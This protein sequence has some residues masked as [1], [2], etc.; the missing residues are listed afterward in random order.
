MIQ[1][2]PGDN[3]GVSALITSPKR[4]YITVSDRW[5]RV[6]DGFTSPWAQRARF[7]VYDNSPWAFPWVSVA[8]PSV[9]VC[10][11]NI[12]GRLDAEDGSI[13][14]AQITVPQV[15]NV[16]EFVPGPFTLTLS[17]QWQGNMV[18]LGGRTYTYYS[19]WP[20]S[21]YFNLTGTLGVQATYSSLVGSG[22]PPTFTWQ[23]A[24]WVARRNQIKT[25]QIPEN[26]MRFGI[27]LAPYGQQT[28]GGWGQ[29]GPLQGYVFPSRVPVI[30][31]AGDNFY[32]DLETSYTYNNGVWLNPP[33]E[34][35]E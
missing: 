28:G 22:A 12:H 17:G 15:I 7:Y 16:V 26:W 25:Y 32:W 10:D 30:P 4:G 20:C 3:V 24:D 1:R 18:T 21:Y 6:S 5:T 14:E 2:A 8:P 11:L 35:T 29:T 13:L 34:P 9:G 23:M 31:K 33:G 27:V 19:P